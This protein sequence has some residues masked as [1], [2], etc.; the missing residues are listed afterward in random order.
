ML[1]DITLKITPKMV[2]DAQGNEKKALVGHIGTHFAG[3]RR[4]KEHS[5]RI[6]LLAYFVKDELPEELILIKIIYQ[7]R[8]CL[9][10]W[11]LNSV[12][13]FM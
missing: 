8:G 9:K 1:I 5:W 4:G 10:S 12:E 2:T 7:C 6:T 11:D 3:V 13:L